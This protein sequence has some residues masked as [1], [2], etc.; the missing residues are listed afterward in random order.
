[1]KYSFDQ[2]DLGR[3]LAPDV[4]E[5]LLVCFSVA[6]QDLGVAELW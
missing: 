2:S 1:M 6:V 5:D 3:A 4:F